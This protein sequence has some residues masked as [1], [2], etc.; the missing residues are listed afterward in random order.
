MTATPHDSRKAAPSAGD[1]EARPD[2]RAP[3]APPPAPS[4]ELQSANQPPEN[5]ASLPAAIALELEELRAKA[6]E[7]DVLRKKANE[8]DEFLALAQRVQADFANYQK[9]MAEEKERR[10]KYLV[11]ELVRDLL[12]ALDA[13]D[14]CAAVAADD[15]QVRAHLAGLQIGVKELARALEKTGLRPI[16][17]ADGE[18]D[19]SVHEAVGMVEAPDRPENQ[20]AELMR[21][22]YRLHER[23]LRPAQVKVTR[24]PAASGEEPGEGKPAAP[25]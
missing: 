13:F 11:G 2:A 9:R 4:P 7:L 17:P 20:V 19:P 21:K 6:A 1:S 3:A 25:A 16:A 24:K 23:V 14:A 12:P 5:M 18:F 10:L 15:A 8:R 22:G